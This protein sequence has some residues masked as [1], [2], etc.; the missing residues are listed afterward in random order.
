MIPPPLAALRDLALDLRW[1]WSRRADALWARIDADLWRQT[2]NPWTL[3]EDVPAERLAALAEDGGFLAHLEG[4]A[5][6]RRAYLAAP[7]WFAA[8]HGG[9]A[10]AGIAYFCLEFG[11]DG[12]L[13]PYAGGLG[14]LAGDYLKTAS[15]LGVPAIG[16]GLLYQEGY[17]RQM[18]DASGWQQE[19][20]PYNEPGM[21][22]IE[23][24]LDQAGTRLHILL[25]LPG[26]RLRL[27]VWRARVGRARLYLLD[28]NDALNTPVDR[29]I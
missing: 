2:R 27:R 15:D 24:V 14:I 25:D 20:Y 9:D 19:A 23:P 6:E 18:I 16:I 13:P 7:G 4:L 22:P 28:S 1:T 26:R 21:M 5:A 29:G 11:L 12:A 3:L 10:I 17:F 8:T